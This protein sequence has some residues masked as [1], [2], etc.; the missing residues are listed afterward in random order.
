MAADLEHQYAQ[1]ERGDSD[2]GW[3]LADGDGYDDAEDNEAEDEVPV[4]VVEDPGAG[5]AE[6]AAGRGGAGEADGALDE[7]VE[8]RD[9]EDWG[10]D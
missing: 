9:A 7:G 8:A 5:A 3:V 2:T 10:E 4:E 6:G 1:R